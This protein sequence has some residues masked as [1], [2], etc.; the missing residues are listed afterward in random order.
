[1]PEQPAEPV[2]QPLLVLDLVWFMVL[3]LVFVVALR[4]THHPELEFV[5]AAGEE[6]RICKSR[7]LVVAAACAATA[8]AVADLAARFVGLR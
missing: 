5:P 1:M 8:T 3:L 6:P 7:L 4:N 2:R